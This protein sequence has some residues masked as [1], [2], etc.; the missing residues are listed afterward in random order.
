MDLS[1]AIVAESTRNEYVRASERLRSD[2][3]IPFVEE[4]LITSAEVKL[5]AVDDKETAD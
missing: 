4:F 3:N 2:E 1:A 5:L